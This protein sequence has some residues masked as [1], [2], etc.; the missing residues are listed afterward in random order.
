M[1]MAL[2][3][4]LGCVAALLLILLVVLLWT[5]LSGRRRM[6]HALSAS[7]V[8]VEVLR[9]R[10]EAM[11]E[12]IEAARVVAAAAAVVPPTEYLITSAGAADALEDEAAMVSNRAVL[13]MT[14]GEPLV[15]V[16]AFGYGVRRALSPETRNRIAFEMRREVKRARK[17]RKRDTRR[18]ARE[19]A[20]K[21]DRREA[22]A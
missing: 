13:S 17:Q 9:T 15:K 18:E 22:A 11:S 4:V 7:R 10:L 19:A 1:E 8:D 6:K 5:V 20:S 2:L 12:E 16:V 21:P 14:F 3:V